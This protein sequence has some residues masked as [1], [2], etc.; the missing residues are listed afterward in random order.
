MARIRFAPPSASPRVEVD[1]LPARRRSG[2]FRP[3]QLGRAD[4]AELPAEPPAAPPADP[5]EVARAQAQALGLAQG[6]E[7]GHAAGRAAY[8]EALARLS[9]GL[10]EITQLRGV[11]GEVYRREVIELALAAAEALVQRELSQSVDAIGGLVDQALVALGDEERLTLF[12]SPADA[13]RI[14]VDGVTIEV[15][16]TLSFGDLRLESEAGSVESAMQRRIAR[17][18]QLVLGE[19]DGGAS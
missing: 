2:A 16:E 10:A 19:L 6:L 13:E 14:E 9:T 5:V 18:R 12:L 11:L 3:W 17:M 15:D 1:P 8:A 4:V 7:D